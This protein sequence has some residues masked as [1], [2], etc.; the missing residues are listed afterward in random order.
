MKILAVSDEPVKWI[1]SAT[2]RERCK[3]V[4]LVVGCGDLPIWY[5]EFIASALDARCVYVH[6]NHDSFEI[7]EEGKVKSHADGWTNLDM[8]VQTIGGLT[9]A[10]LEG[11]LRY[12][13]DA[14]FQYSQMQQ[15]MRAGVLASRLLTRLLT[16]KSFD[17]MVTHSPPYGI[18]NGVD[19]A[20]TGFT[21]FN[22][23]ME[24]FRPKLWLHGH[25]HTNYAPRDATETQIGA[26]KVINVHPFRILE[27]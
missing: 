24:T 4:Q 3:D 15:K 1:Y 14:P 16:A 11:C 25:Q 8:N 9:M 26:T 19:H 22:W 2:L 20:H 21:S 27:I 12:K 10:G 13:P 23:L 18:H 6:G 5:M 17:L 7:Q